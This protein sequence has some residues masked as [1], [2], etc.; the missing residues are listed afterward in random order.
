MPDS[1]TTCIGSVRIWNSTAVPSGLDQ[2]GVQRLVAVDLGDGDVVLEAAGH[3]LVQLV[4]HAQ[5]DVALGA[6]SRRRRESR[7]CRSPGRS[8]GASRASCGRSSTASSRGRQI[9][10]WHAGVARTPSRRRAA[11]SRP[12]RAGGRAPS[13]PPCAERRVA[14]RLQ[15]LER[16]L[17][18]LAV[19][20]V[21]AEPV[22]DRR[23]DVERLARRCA[24][25]S[26]GRPRPCV[27]ML[28][29]RSASLIRMT[30]T[31]R[32]IASS[33]LR[34]DS[35]CDFLAGGEL[36][37]VELGQAV[38]Q[39]GGRRAEA[40]DQ[41]RLGD[42]AI[43]HRVV[44]QRRHDRLRVE[45]PLGALAGDRDR[46]GDVGLAAGAELAEVGFVGEAV[47]LADLLDVGRVEVVELG[48]QRGERWRLRRRRRARPWRRG[49]GR[50]FG[51]GLASRSRRWTSARP[52]PEFSAE[53]ACGRSVGAADGQRLKAGGSDMAPPEV[54]QRLRPGPCAASRGRPRRRRSRAAR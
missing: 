31:S 28:C 13:A 4:Q 18:Q 37:L 5:R 34:N 40:L 7:R 52:C 15:V 19:G 24:S 43:L 45:L 44:H 6:A 9:C 11:P 26:R 17:L 46:V 8:S 53:P 54:R 33:I 41:L 38:D 30:R 32:A 12:G 51:A 25:A 29:R 50:L 39:F 22:R 1:A 16:Q 42:A 49:G 27:R 2:R 20:L 14:P 10:T 47:G 21:Q 48:G 3:R 35:A 36:Q 23:V